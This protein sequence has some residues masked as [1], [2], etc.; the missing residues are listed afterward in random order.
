MAMKRSNV[1]KWIIIVA[2][3][4]KIYMYNLESFS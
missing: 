1:S 3:P 4:K 2:V